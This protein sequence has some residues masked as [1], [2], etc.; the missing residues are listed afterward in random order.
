MGRSPSLADSSLR[1][2]TADNDS[3][4]PWPQDESFRL[5]TI[6]SAPLGYPPLYSCIYVLLNIDQDGKETVLHVGCTD[7][8]Q[9]ALNGPPWPNDHVPTHVAVKY[10]P[11]PNHGEYIACQKETRYYRAKFGLTA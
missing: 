4:R 1:P 9:T 3:L 10:R 2:M 6:T 11:V 8:L 5:N 7:D